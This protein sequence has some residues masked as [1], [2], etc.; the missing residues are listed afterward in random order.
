M[1]RLLGPAMT[2]SVRYEALM[3][4]RQRALWV[5]TVPLV[6]FSVLIAALSPSL[7]GL[8]LTSAQVGAWSLIIN[9]FA[10]LGVAVALADRLARVRRRGL[11][12]LLDVTAARPAVRMVGGLLGALAVAL[13]PLTAAMLV[14]GAGFALTRHDPA[15][16][17]WALLALAVVI[18]PA[19]L[20]ATAFAATLALLLPVPLAR[21]LTVGAWGWATVW[22]T[23]IIPIPTLSGTVLSPLGEYAAHG[24]LHAPTLHGGSG[25]ALLR[26][27]A[28]PANAAIA[29]A[30]LL[31]T[32]I[33]LLAIARLLRAART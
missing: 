7:S 28:T 26:P 29:L 2:G 32:T 3:A 9:L 31:A 24:W 25:T 1:S 13:I 33:A 30:A 23:T 22:N 15:A 6:G 19:A 21:V 16:V 4:A 14:V 27:P 17:G 20:L 12:D 10:T 5:A 8:H 18:V 11:P